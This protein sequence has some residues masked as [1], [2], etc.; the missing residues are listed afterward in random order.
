MIFNYAIGWTKISG[1]AER[2]SLINA[3]VSLW[4]LQLMDLYIYEMNV[5]R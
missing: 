5:S 1:T 2:N 4:P 3:K